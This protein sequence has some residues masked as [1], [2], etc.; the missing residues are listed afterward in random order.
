MA[1]GLTDK[2]INSGL[3]WPGITTQ[4]DGTLN[5]SYA[6]FFRFRSISAVLGDRT[7][8]A[9]SGGRVI[10][11]P[12]SWSRATT[13]MSGAN[14]V[15]RDTMTAGSGTTCHSGGDAR[16]RIDASVNATT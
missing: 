16:S 11:V 6:A 8:T 5:R 15:S 1:G 10:L 9:R 2:A 3:P 12:E 7:S 14:S 4:Y 13:T